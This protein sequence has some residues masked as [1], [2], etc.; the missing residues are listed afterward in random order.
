LSVAVR[1]GLPLRADALLEWGT[2][3]LREI[4]TTPRFE[5]ELLLSQCT[6]LGRARLLGFPETRIDASVRARFGELVG[7]RALG[8]PIAYLSGAR[9]FYALDF[10]VSAAVLVPRPETELLVDQAL[11]RLN[12]ATKA[13]VLDLGTGSGAIAIAVKHHRPEADLTAVDLSPAALDLARTNAAAHGA[14]IRFLCSDWFD[15]LAGSE[16]FDLILSNP[17]YVAADDPHW[18]ALRHEPRLALDGGPGGLAAF[19]RIL[20]GARAWLRPG[21]SLV[22]EH[23]HD[24]RAAIVELAAAQ[25]WHCSG[26]FQDLAG[27]DRVLAFEVAGA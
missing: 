19:A 8:V 16:P 4:T 22:L 1:D 18:P 13:R 27:L 23:G 25:G 24:Q 26:S 7:Q 3:V 17:P 20:A 10:A 15:A 9:E 21:G 2:G 5:A 6:G 14:Q 11:S 12:P